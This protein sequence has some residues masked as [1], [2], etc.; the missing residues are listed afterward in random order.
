MMLGMINIKCTIEK[1]YHEHEGI[2]LSIDLSRVIEKGIAAI[3]ALLEQKI[4]RFDLI[5]SASG[6]CITFSVG[7]ATWNCANNDF[8]LFFPEEQLRVLQDL[9]L[10][11]FSKKGFDGYHGDFEL[12]N[13]GRELDMCFLLQHGVTRYDKD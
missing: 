7:N 3:D 11:V 4:S 8:F 6:C 2:G 13:E 1:M 9:M 12:V 5:D 10:D